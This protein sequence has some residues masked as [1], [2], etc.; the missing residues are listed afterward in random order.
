MKLK[1]VFLVIT[2]VLLSGCVQKEAPEL[3]RPGVEEPEGWTADGVVGDGEYFGS[4]VLYGPESRGYSGGDLEVFWTTDDEHLYMALRG[5]TTGWIS[6]GFDPLEWMKDADV[7]MGSVDGKKVVVEDQY[8]TDSYGPHL[9]D[10][11]LGGTD[12]ILEFGGQEK[13][14]H[15]VIEFKRRL[16]TGDQFD[17]VISPGQEL[18]VI[19]S[20][21]ESD[22]LQASHNVARA[23]G[24][25]NLGE[26]A[27]VATTAAAPMALTAGERDGILFI[28]EEERMAED[29]YLELYKIVKLPIFRNVADSEQIH[30]DSVAILMDRYGLEDP[31]Q[32]GDGV[33]ANETLQKMYDDLL[34]SGGKSPEDALR[35]AAL[36]EET[37]VHD[38]E[39]RIRAT[40]KP[41]IRSVYGGLLMGSEK[42]L[43][44]FV[45]ALE[46]RGGEYSPQ[47]LSREEFADIVKA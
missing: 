43:R 30:M 28:R 20:M 16:D 11:D 22:D 31:V 29:L 27:G 10:E 32:D 36:V 44:S 7:I 18:S 24:R 1:S 34:E 45:R 21:A 37:S 38:L 41:E 26:K 19:W 3:E 46:E 23:E 12:D 35:A 42:H 8:S 9:P 4:A 39:K 2:L 13:D 5:E 14:G 17:K 47:L 40:D 15:T 25:L 6:I 33:Y